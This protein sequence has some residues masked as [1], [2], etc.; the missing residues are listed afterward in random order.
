MQAEHYTFT[1]EHQ[2]QAAY[3]RFIKRGW[4]ASAPWQ[5]QRGTWRV[6]VLFYGR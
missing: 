6:T 1:S 2:A 3:T 5:D 4:T